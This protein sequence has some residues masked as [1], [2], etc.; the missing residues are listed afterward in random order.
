MKRITR[1]LAAVGLGL[2]TSKVLPFV[3]KYE[4]LLLQQK[5]GAPDRA[6]Q[7]IDVGAPTP[8]PS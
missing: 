7:D 8:T 1:S 3:D 4:Q 2:A 6:G 5:I